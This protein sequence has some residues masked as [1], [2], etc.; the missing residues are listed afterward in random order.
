MSTSSSTVTT[1]VPSLLPAKTEHD[2]K[3]NTDAITTVPPKGGNYK[4]FVA[5]VFSGAAKLSVGYI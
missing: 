5:G 3:T 4:A 1:T 2:P